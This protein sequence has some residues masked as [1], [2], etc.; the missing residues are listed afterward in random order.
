MVSS[1]HDGSDEILSAFCQSCITGEKAE[2]VVEEAYYS[3]LLCLLG[4]KAME[5]C[6]TID[7]PE[8]YKIPYMSF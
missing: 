3:T 1:D 5:E 4:N 6:A 7:F 8:E 2:N